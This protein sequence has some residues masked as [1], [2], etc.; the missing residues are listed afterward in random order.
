MNNPPPP[1]KS[2]R[3]NG[4]AL[5][6]GIGVFTIVAVHAAFSLATGAPLNLGEE[7]GIFLSQMLLVAAPFG[8]LALAEVR[9]GV[10]WLVGGAFTATLWGYYLFD[11]IR[12]QL[13]DEISGANIGLGLMLLVSPVF[14][15]VACLATAAFRR[16]LF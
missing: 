10:A 8:L 12:Y 7:W 2:R 15:S 5:A 16:R 13:S 11:G 14:I 9:D 6:L 1:A 3:V 4:C